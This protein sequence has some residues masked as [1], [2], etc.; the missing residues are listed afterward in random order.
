MFR[1]KK[2]KRVCVYRKR[3]ERLWLERFD[4]TASVTEPAE[5]SNLRFIVLLTLLQ[6]SLNISNAQ[7]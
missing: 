7:Q 3:V 2:K 1:I 4:H 5:T 6:F